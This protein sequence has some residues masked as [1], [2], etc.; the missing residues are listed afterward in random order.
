MERSK[1]IIS[2][3]VG[4][5]A[6]LIIWRVGFYP[7]APEQT[8]KPDETEVAAEPNLPGDVNEPMVSFNDGESQ[9]RRPGGVDRPVR[10]FPGS[11]P[12]S[13]SLLNGPA[14]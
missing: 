13:R 2:I 3:V 1:S 14:R 7:P 11:E 8:G 4:L 5:A 9:R 12:S 10:M 6:I